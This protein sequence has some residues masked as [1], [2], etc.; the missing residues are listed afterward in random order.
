MLPKLLEVW[1]SIRN[2]EHNLRIS[3]PNSAQTKL[4]L[5]LDKI[6]TLESNRRPDGQTPL[7]VE[8][9]PS[10]PKYF[11]NKAKWN[12]S[13]WQ[14]EHGKLEKS[15][16]SVT[17]KMRLKK[18]LEIQLSTQVN[19]IATLDECLANL[20]EVRQSEMEMS[21]GVLEIPKT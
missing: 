1:L 4:Q 17:Q 21:S 6:K 2:P 16:S 7:V 15:D 18:I 12:Q 10:S 13:I 8:I 9:D 5:R 14:S 3:H 20:K 11:Q 19:K